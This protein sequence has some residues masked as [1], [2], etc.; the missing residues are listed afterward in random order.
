MNWNRVE[1]IE[2]TDL[3]SQITD[4]LYSSPAILT[5]EL[6]A[7]RS[8]NPK[9][10][11]FEMVKT[12]YRTDQFLLCT[13]KLEEEEEDDDDENENKYKII[14]IKHKELQTTTITNNLKLKANLLFIYKSYYFVELINN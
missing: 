6:I 5:N 3:S 14:F 2:E 11:S 4:H 13:I 8:D 9:Q 1:E 7:S 10:I 12:N